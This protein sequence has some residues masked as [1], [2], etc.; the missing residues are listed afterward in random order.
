MTVYMPL[1]TSQEIDACRQQFYPH[2]TRDVM[3]QRVLLYNGVPR[4][5]LECEPPV[6]FESI[7]QSLNSLAV[8]VSIE[9]SVSTDLVSDRL[10]VMEPDG[11]IKY[12]VKWTSM[13]LKRL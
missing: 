12:R 5:V 13:L 7:A 2:V 11:Y 1:W 3:D 4:Y 10:V 9:T 8:F 6:D